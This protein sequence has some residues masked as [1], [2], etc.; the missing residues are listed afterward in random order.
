MK[1]L[2]GWTIAALLAAGLAAPFGCD[3]GGGGR[4]GDADSDSDS[5]SDTDEGPT[6]S[7]HGTVLAPSGG[8]PIPGALVY[9]T[10]GDGPEIPDSIYC[11]E[12]E[13]MTGKKWALSN[14]D[15]TWTLEDVPVGDWNIV[16]RKGF[17]QRQRAVV[18]DEGQDL[19]VPVEHTTLPGDNS[20][21]GLD[22]IPNYAVL[23]TS[24]DET[25]KLLGKIGMGT[26]NGGELAW[27]SETFDIFNDE[28]SASGYPS[29]TALFMDQPTLD[30][31]HMIF[32]PCFA[33]SVGTSFVDSH[34]GMIQGYVAGGGKIYN[35]C[36]VAY[37]IEKPFPAYLDFAA[38]WY[39]DDSGAWDIGRVSGS[40]LSTSG[41]I[42]DQGMRDWMQ[43]VT[44][45]NI[46]AVPFV[47][48]YAKVD[49]LI[50]VDDGHGLDDDDGVVKP[51]AW[52]LGS[53]ADV[54]QN[55]SLMT[56]YDYECGKVFFSV[57][58]TSQNSAVITPQEFVLIYI[59]LE[60][61]VCE[62]DYVP[63]E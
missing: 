53:A 8:F 19:D 18:V 55:A 47:N 14:A 28:I 25:Y 49:N 27:G 21:D 36:C 62:G 46:D 33:S 54:Y 40:A 63:P 26:M 17:F 39:D 4:G 31:Y 5:D 7:M 41:T 35:S 44:S 1:T 48:G 2:A 37:W 57:Y 10:K 50:E 6:G 45:A 3:D 11:Y 20:A 42:V 52:V 61:G 13:D 16:T 12:C 60:V 9:L 15:G 43:V 59:I 51:Y 30:H 22:Q 58:E 56:T 23:G 29:P 32:L 34:V 24:P 38:D